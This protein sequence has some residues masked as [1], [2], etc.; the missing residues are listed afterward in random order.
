MPNSKD[1]AAE[2]KDFQ[3]KY[4]LPDYDLNTLASLDKK[5]Y[6]LNNFLTN[7]TAG[8]D[9]AS[10]FTSWLGKTLSVYF[11]RNTTANDSGKYMSSFKPKEFLTD[12]DRLADAKYRSELKEYDEHERKK[13]AG[14]RNRDIKR[15][16][17]NSLKDMN[18][19][20][21]TMWK[22]KLK[23][24][25]I[26][27]IDLQA[28]TMNIMDIV[29]N[30]QA[31]KTGLDEKITTVVAA[32]EAL[33]QLRESRKGIIGWFWKQFNKD[34]NEIEKVSLGIFETAV[35]ELRDNG[36]DVDKIAAD[37]TGKTVLG[38]EVEGAARD[39]TQPNAAEAVNEAPIPQ[40]TNISIPDL[41]ENSNAM[42]K[43]PKIDEV[44]HNSPDLSH[45][46]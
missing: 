19:T 45:N 40:K 22:D 11:E 24:G 17:T 41:A 1:Y 21:P 31:D 38:L 28:H 5:F 4:N 15:V 10:E 44:T 12:F 27:A 37:L 43:S 3:R 9:P 46:K 35:N 23:K 26:K 32:H 2:L 18:K 30:P 6:Y 39:A 34:R 13:Y 33:K 29:R 14:A 20:L 16:L 8:H 25:T 7:D 36:Y 42:D